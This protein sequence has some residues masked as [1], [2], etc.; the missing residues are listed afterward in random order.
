MIDVTTSHRDM[1]TRHAR[2]RNRSP[3][4]TCTG[5]G[6]A[7]NVGGRVEAGCGRTSSS[8]SLGVTRTHQL[9]GRVSIICLRR[10]TVVWKRTETVDV[11]RRLDHRW[12]ILSGTVNKFE[13][14]GAVG[15]PCQGMRDTVTEDGAV[16]Q[17]VLY[18]PPPLLYIPHSGH[19]PPL[20]T[21]P[22]PSVP[23]TTTPHPRT[24]PGARM[25]TTKAKPE[26]ETLTISTTVA[27]VTHRLISEPQSLSLMEL[28]CRKKWNGDFIH[29]KP[30][31][32]KW[33]SSREIS[34]RNHNRRGATVRRSGIPAKYDACTPAKVKV[35]FQNRRMKHKRQTLSKQG[36]D[37]D[38]K[39]ST[40]SEG[41]KSSKM[42][43]D[44]F[45]DDEM[46]KKSC[47][48]CEMPGGPG[49]GPH[50]DMITEDDSRSNEDSGVH[51][52][53]RASTK[54]STSSSTT[55]SS[56]SV[57]VEGRKNS[58]NANS[59]RRIG[60][61]KTS[62]TGPPKDACGNGQGLLMALSDGIP[63]GS[64]GMSSRSLT[65]SSTPGTPAM[66]HQ[67]PI[68]PPGVANPVMY[69]QLP[70][71]SP[72]TATAIA[73]AT[74][75][76]QNVSNA[77]PPFV[78]RGAGSIGHFQNQYPVAANNM[79]YRNESHR[80][81][82][83][84]HSANAQQ[85]QMHHQQTG[86]SSGDM[87]NPEHPQHMMA[88]H[89]NVIVGAGTRPNEINQR[90]RGHIR[91]NYHHT[92]QQ[93]H[94]QQ[95][96]YYANYNKNHHGS[97]GTDSTSYHHSMNPQTGYNHTYNQHHAGYNN[98]YGYHASGI[99]PSEGN[100]NMTAPHM[101]NSAAAHM[102]Q[103]DATSTAAGY[104]GGAENI[105]QMHKGQH[106]EY[107]PSNK[108]PTDTAYYENNMYN[109]M[110]ANHTDPSSGYPSTDGFQQ[111]APVVNTATAIAAATAAVM[112]PP[113]SV[114]TEPG[115][116]Y[117][118]FHQFYAGETP[119]TQ[120]TPASGENSNNSADFNF[121]SNLANDFAPE[122]YQ[123]S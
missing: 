106:V 110:N 1:H 3:R 9:F 65:P 32:R 62:P 7:Q 80:T 34:Y 56:I 26:I 59:E 116:N 15:K 72:T 97:S 67:N 4:D 94:N 28:H 6:A 31:V 14:W 81:A 122:Y 12:S 113:T 102:N 21:P 46:S 104:Y 84:H 63:S 70:R 30:A 98:H 24:T 68:G 85:F 5:E 95:Q 121:L 107:I 11:S 77:V 57:K 35:W 47:Q 66:Q 111:S 42:S 16:N 53:P 36:E 54:K 117:N 60:M 74:V 123:L 33:R 25:P 52:S 50:D 109:H 45:L 103:Q 71:S 93:Y 27:Y 115:D 64:K 90:G 23:G 29:M 120:P 18:A 51:T 69:P 41:G 58:P 10:L 55:A 61:C 82:A 101:P 91:Q 39:D 114:Q 108:P 8:S 17:K 112:T 75:T 96:H 43:S 78:A 79:D 118:S 73:S 13:L 89:Q 38:D 22:M 92:T 20:L 49:C 76:I 87:Y 99:Y 105:H 119:Q 88:N 48:G 83:K 37:G 40:A 44:K 86:Y 100:E 19:P 2:R